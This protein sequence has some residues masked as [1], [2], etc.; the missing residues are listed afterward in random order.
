MRKSTLLCRIRRKGTR[1]RK[2]GL[3][4]L[5][6]GAQILVNCLEEQGVQNIFGYPGASIL[7]VYDCLASSSIRH[8]L[9]AHEQGAC[10]AA[11]GYARRS[12]KAGVVLATS[13][14]GAT[15]LLTGIADAY[16]DSVPLVAVTGNVPLDQ[17][18]HDSFQ[19]VDVFDMSMPVTKYSIIVK[20]ATDLAA[21]V[22]KAFLIAE[23]GRKGPVLVDIPCNVFSEYADYAKCQPEKPAVCAPDEEEIRKAA[24]AIA[25]AKRPVI[26]AGGGIKWSG[27]EHELAGLAQKLRAPVTVSYMGIGCFDPDDEN[28]LGV[29][30]NTNFK[31]SSALRECDLLITLGARFNSRYAAFSALKKRRTPLLQL[32]ADKAEIDKNILTTASVT[33][34][35]K[36]SL[37]K[38]LPLV[39]ERDA[40]EEWEFRSLPDLSEENCGID[41][42]KCLCRKLGPSATVTTDV[43]LHQEWAAHNCKVYNSRRFL[44]SGGLGAMGFGLGAA[45]GAHFASGDVCLLITGDGSFNMNFNEIT[46]AVKHHV[47]LVV[48]VLNNNSLG[49]IRKLQSERRAKTSGISSLYLNVDYA[50]LA[51]SMGARGV[52]VEEFSDLDAVLDDALEGSLPLVIDFKIPINTGI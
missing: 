39:E 5:S 19:E 48:A 28:Y 30:C 25:T 17:L 3:K 35:L 23:S 50:A 49:M 52:T 18:G 32:D 4:M 12:G 42:I 21:A 8:V 38:L 16:M 13:G 11:E 7:P 26:Y 27:A 20:R 45:I 47:P 46:T 44:T 15:N 9:T 31:T 36:L 24:Q 40:A 14:P 2:N 51:Q 33:G 37:S 1:E 6:S 10:F 43:G 22:R 41:I 34:D 29:L